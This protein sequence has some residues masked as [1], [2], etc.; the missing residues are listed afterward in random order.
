MFYNCTSLDYIKC[1]ATDISAENC[2]SN[3][4][5]RVSSTGTFVKHPDMNSWSTG[6][7]GIPEGWAVEDAEI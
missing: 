6:Y 5:I 3:W 4:V 1:Q 7:V 2:T